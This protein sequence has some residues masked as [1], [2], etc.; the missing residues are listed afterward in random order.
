MQGVWCCCCCCCCTWPAVLLYPSCCLKASDGWLGGHPGQLEVLYIKVY[1]V[2]GGVVWCGVVWCGV[3]WCGVVWCLAVWCG[4]AALRKASGRE[5]PGH[6]TSCCNMSGVP[7]ADG[8]EV[9]VFLVKATEGC[10]IN[11]SHGGEQSDE[12]LAKSSW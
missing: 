7:R 8:E 5:Y 12:K 11:N 3:W 4:V 6:V 9:P 1:V 10:S 2:S